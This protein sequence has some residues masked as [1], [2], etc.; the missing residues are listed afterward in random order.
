M[1]T[2]LG[3]LMLLFKQV[4]SGTARLGETGQGTA[5]IVHWSFRPKMQKK[6]AFLESHYKMF[7]LIDF[8][9]I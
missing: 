5:S 2:V 7:F 9:G 3:T 4:K 1:L 8:K 6:I